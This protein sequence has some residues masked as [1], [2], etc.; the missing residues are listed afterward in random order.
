MRLAPRLIAVALAFV[1]STAAAQD[2]TAPGSTCAGGDIS[3][4]MQQ[5]NNNAIYLCTTT[6]STRNW[7]PEPLYLGSSSST[8]DA[9][10]EGLHRYNATSHYTE[11]CNGS[12]WTALVQVQSTPA[13]TA[14]SGSGYF[15]MT[16]TSYDGNL[17]GLSGADAKCLTEL[18]TT[19]TSWRGYSSANSNG[20]IT[21]GKV[22]AFLCD[23]SICNNLMPLTTYYFAY[24]NS[25]T[26][27]GAS[28]TTD[29]T[30]LAPGDSNAWSAA[31]YFSG[32]YTYWTARNDNPGSGVT[33]TIWTNGTE[34]YGTC[35]YNWSQSGSG[36]NGQ[37]GSSSATDSQRWKGASDTCNNAKRLICFVNP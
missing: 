5:P 32:T 37:T 15:V 25:G 4:G 20:Q 3:A 21:A 28:F 29:S 14:P 27:G 10:H 23:A 8:C 17:G 22:H 2:A 16:E 30:G 19:N 18:G 24:A 11:V 36:Y 1:A 7:Y 9:S 26:P 34:Y 33:P 31:N 13:I 6:G 12:A 35:N